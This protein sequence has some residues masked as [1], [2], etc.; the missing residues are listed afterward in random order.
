MITEKEAVKLLKKYAQ[1]HEQFKM[2]YSHAKAVQK[3]ALE[4]ASKVDGVDMELIRIGS[5]LHDIGRFH[6]PPGNKS[7]R[8]GIEGARILRKEGLP[9]IALIAERHVGFGITEEDIK[10]Q[11]LDLPLQ[12]YMPITKEEK[13]ISWADNLCFGDEVGT[14]DE[15]IAKYKKEVGD[16]ILEKIKRFEKEIQEMTKQDT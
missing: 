9:A 4:I 16:Y 3:V 15:V 14:V 10:R 8:H 7:I 13:I 11:G 1:S 6:F 5:L 12:D 2:V